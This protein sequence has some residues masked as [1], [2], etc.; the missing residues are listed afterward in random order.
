M[1]KIQYKKT[2][3]LDNQKAQA[4]IKIEVELPEYLKVW[5]QSAQKFAKTVTM[6]GFRKGKVPL[7]TVKS[8]KYNEISEQAYNQMVNLVIQD[9]IETADQRPISTIRIDFDE[10]EHKEGETHSEDESKT[11][12]FSLSYAYRTPAKLADVANIKAK[13]PEI[14]VTDEEVKQGTEMLLNSINAK[15]EETGKEKIEELNDESIKELLI[16]DVN[17][18]EDL[19]S[20]VKTEIEKQKSYEL[21]LNYKGQIL[22]ELVKNSELTIPEYV[23]EDN[24]A[25]QENDYKKRIEK[26]GLDYDKFITDKSVNMDDLKKEWETMIRT[27]LSRELVLSQYAMDN[28]IEPSEEELAQ[29]VKNAPKELKDRYDADGLE[30]Y[31]KYLLGNNMAFNDI[32]KKVDAMSD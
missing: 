4:D 12:K 18:V 17:T 16:S 8:A 7:N 30:E 3:D 5:E 29:A 31:Y 25:K 1:S 11:I 28:K 10:H 6:P 24:V 13:R 15:R 23:I 2:V 14:E 19:K 22:D 21:D 32:F 9:V 20:L 27:D 26:L